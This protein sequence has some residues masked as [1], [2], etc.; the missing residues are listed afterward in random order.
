MQTAYMYEKDEK[1]DQTDLVEYIGVRHLFP[2]P[3]HFFLRIAD[4]EYSMPTV[5]F[6]C[7]SMGKKKVI[8]SGIYRRSDDSFHI[9]YACKYSIYDLNKYLDSWRSTFQ[10][11]VNITKN[12]INDRVRMFLGRALNPLLADHDDYIQLKAWL[13]L[14]E[15][16][17]YVVDM[18]N[19]IATRVEGLISSE[20][21]RRL[22]EN[23]TEL[24]EVE[25][26]NVV[27]DELMLMG[28]EIGAWDISDNIEEYLVMA[29]RKLDDMLETYE[30]KMNVV[31][32][33]KKDVDIVR[34]SEKFYDWISRSRYVTP[35]WVA[36]LNN[37]SCS[38][39]DPNSPG[40]MIIEWGKRSIFFK[41]H[42]RE[43]KRVCIRP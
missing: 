13:S 29:V 25:R 35:G 34:I 41:K 27:I 31:E 37:C 16:S 21:H 3:F 24:Q 11:T 6:T 8:M 2:D 17:R 12:R 32:K 26:L 42:K 38:E 39:E 43:Y 22:V 1:T 15:T 5:R 40:C 33:Q 28:D 23:I 19:E 18:D 10:N 30:Q 36:E 9:L 14:Q 20:Y 4:I 7:F